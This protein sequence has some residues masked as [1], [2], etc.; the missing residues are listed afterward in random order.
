[1]L[2][3][4]KM[5]KYDLTDGLIVTNE[6]VIEFAS[7]LNM[8]LVDFRVGLQQG[9]YL[10]NLIDS[11]GVPSRV[12]ECIY[13]NSA[14][15]N[16]D[17]NLNLLKTDIL[18]YLISEDTNLNGLNTEVTTLF[19]ELGYKMGLID[20]KYYIKF[21]SYQAEGEYLSLDSQALKKT[22]M[23]NDLL[24]YG[25]SGESMF[26]IMEE[27]RKNL[28]KIM[29]GEKINLNQDFYRDLFTE[30]LIYIVENSL[31]F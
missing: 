31:W 27:I 12:G 3:A 24:W 30:R 2:E 17:K 4:E 18:T 14:M 21:P 1:M 5:F 13:Y 25:F 7:L 15:K 23:E 20:E 9:K 22:S 6:K 8:A 19:F 16:K 29:K 11:N 28:L 10:K 26:F